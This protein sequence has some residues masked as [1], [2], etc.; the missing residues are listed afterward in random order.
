[1][2]CGQFV[3]SAEAEKL[4]LLEQFIFIMTKNNFALQWQISPRLQPA[5]SNPSI[6]FH[7]IATKYN[8]TY[9]KYKNTL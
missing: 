3:H 7:F 6:S 1:M 5:T 4:L 9:N 2:E 8:N